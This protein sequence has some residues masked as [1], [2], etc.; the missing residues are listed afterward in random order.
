MES[1][2]YFIDNPD[3]ILTQLPDGIRKAYVESAPYLVQ[4][5]IIL[6]IANDH[7]SLDLS[8]IIHKLENLIK[9]AENPLS[10]DL[11]IFL[12]KI[13]VLISNHE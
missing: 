1:N 11:K 9:K 4:P 10:T 12:N 13:E 6:K 2:T 8:N 5:H 3:E 7:G